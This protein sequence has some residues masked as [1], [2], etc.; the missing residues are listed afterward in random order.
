MADCSGV[1]NGYHLR[2]T[3]EVFNHLLLLVDLI[4]QTLHVEAFKCDFLGDKLVDTGSQRV[5]FLVDV[6]ERRV[7]NLGL[8][9]FKFAQR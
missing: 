4:K 3:G 8:V 2:L 7:L 9:N 5:K 6:F 1:N